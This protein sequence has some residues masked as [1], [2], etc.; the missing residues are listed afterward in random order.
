MIP[1]AKN[2]MFGWMVASKISVKLATV[3]KI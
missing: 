2:S 1:N 3:A